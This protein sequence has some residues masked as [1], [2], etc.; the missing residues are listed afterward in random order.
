MGLFKK[1]KSFKELTI[2]K[3]RA[4]SLQ[5][6][7]VIIGGGLKDKSEPASI[8]EKFWLANVYIEKLIG[9]DVADGGFGYMDNS[10]ALNV[11]SSTDAFSESIYEYGIYKRKGSF[12]GEVIQ[13]YRLEFLKNY[14]SAGNI[15]PIQTDWARLIFKV[16]DDTIEENTANGML[17]QD[18]LKDIDS[19]I[20]NPWVY[21]GEDSECIL[22]KI[23]VAILFCDDDFVKR[24]GLIKGGKSSGKSIIDTI[25]DDYITFKDV[26]A[27]NS[28]Y[29]IENF[30]NDCQTIG[31]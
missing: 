31:K 13:N 22:Y 20:Y 18:N 29:E 28:K 27:Y 2:E 17:T 19:P 11:V 4:K 25:S 21:S 7:T 12:G 3:Y 1:K 24:Y 8:D 6:L 9:S 23:K 10:A 5:E 30:L 16:Y 26:T 15:K 14:L